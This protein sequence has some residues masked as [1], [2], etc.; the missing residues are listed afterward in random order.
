MART[1][2]T[3]GCGF[4]GR[5][6]AERL[7]ADLP[8]IDLVLADQAPP[9][10]DWKLDHDRLELLTGD[11]TDRSFIE[12]M[13]TDDVDTVF[14]LASVVSAGAEQNFDL[15][16]A[17]NL[18]GTIA[19]LERC[20]EVADATGR[21]PMVV[22]T[23]S[24]ATYGS[25]AGN[26]VVDATALRPET[27]Y[28]VQKAAAELLLNDYHRKGFIDG[29]GLRLPTVVVR[30]G[31][32]NLA[33]SGFA[34]GIVREPLQ[35]IDMVCPVSADTVMAVISP[36]RVID[37]FVRIVELDAAALGPDRTVLLPGLAM[38]M[39]E[40]I[41][42]TRA[43]AG[44]RDLGTVSF[45]PDPDVQRIIDSWPP[46]IVAERAEALGLVG[47]RSVAAIVR[48]HIEDELED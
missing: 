13:M 17:V 33:A 1:L 42:A 21:P 30:P 8:D 31:K 14:H 7:V 2:V 45:L 47:D 44:G 29:R 20:R 4:L 39:S 3:G 32:P 18:L 26:P 37:A 9:P 15:G 24:L 19:V 16:Y 11:V 22:F 23:S 5:K 6:L 40:A 28:G 34:S 46:S 35:G 43:E 36:R 38:S 48:Q 10:A 41:E 12:Q 25:G 27:S